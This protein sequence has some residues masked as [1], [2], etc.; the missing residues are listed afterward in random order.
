MK[1]L[2]ARIGGLEIVVGELLIALRE[3]DSAVGTDLKARLE[4]QL[5]DDGHSVSQHNAILNFLV[6]L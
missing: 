4:R 5:K 6:L 1:E 3:S 2:E